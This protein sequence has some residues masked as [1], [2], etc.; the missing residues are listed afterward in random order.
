MKEVLF[1]VRM[2]AVRNW[3]VMVITHAVLMGCVVRMK[4]TVIQTETAL[5]GLSVA[6]TT[7]KGQHSKVEMI[8]VQRLQV[9]MVVIAAVHGVSVE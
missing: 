8:V 5:Q 3:F 4:A 2:T 1:K 9:V 7:V 6:S